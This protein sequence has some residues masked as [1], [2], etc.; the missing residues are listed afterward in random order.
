MKQFVEERCERMDSHHI[1]SGLLLP[2]T[3]CKTTPSVVKPL[4]T[5]QKCSSNMQ[6]FTFYKCTAML[7]HCG[8]EFSS[9]LGIK[10]LKGY[11]L[12]HTVGVSAVCSCFLSSRL[13]IHMSCSVPWPGGAR[14]PSERIHQWLPTQRSCSGP[15]E[16]QPVLTQREY[17]DYS[18]VLSH[19][20][21]H[22]VQSKLKYKS[23]TLRECS[24]SHTSASDGEVWPQGGVK[25]QIHDL[26]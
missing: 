11:Y 5:H 17:R 1:G 24:E 22:S 8:S 14:L 23:E 6:I 26:N 13:Q 21:A 9:V 19:L 3:S 20:H 4:K 15:S 12:K 16:Q 7:L 2:I 18:C 25:F 10:V